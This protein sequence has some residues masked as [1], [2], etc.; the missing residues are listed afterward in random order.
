VFGEHGDDV[1]REVNAGAALV[2]LFI[3]GGVGG[4][5]G[6]DVGDVDAEEPLVVG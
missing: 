6:A 5:E 1:L 4:D 2:S 3:E